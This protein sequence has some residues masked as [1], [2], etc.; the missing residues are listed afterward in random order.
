MLPK[1]ATFD[2]DWFEK[3]DQQSADWIITAK[4]GSPSNKILRANLKAYQAKKKTTTASKTTTSKKKPSPELPS[5]KLS[6]KEPS[7]YLKVSLCKR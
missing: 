7:G 6:C 2:P 3:R 5:V 1:K 4:R